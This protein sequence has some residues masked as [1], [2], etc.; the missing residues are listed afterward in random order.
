LPASKTC[1]PDPDKI[2]KKT[3]HLTLSFMAALKSAY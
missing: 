3:W 1:H 2:L